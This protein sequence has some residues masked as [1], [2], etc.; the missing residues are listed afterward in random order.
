MIDYESALLGACPCD[1]SPL[2][3]L[4]GPRGRRGGGRRRLG[5]RRYV[6]SGGYAGGETVIVAPILSPFAPMVEWREDDD[7]ELGAIRMSEAERGF[8]LARDAFRAAEREKNRARMDTRIR[9]VR[10]WWNRMTQTERNN[11][12]SDY[13]FLEQL[14]SN[15]PGASEAAAESRARV[16]A[17]R[18][19]L[20][21]ARAAGGTSLFSHLPG[22][23]RDEARG[24]AEGVRK[25][26]AHPLAKVA[27]VAAV[28]LLGYA[29]YLRASGGGRRR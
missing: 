12:A 14:N 13:A 7:A 23:V 19:A 24:M 5:G 11:Y 8:T 3:A 25:V 20:E 16:D 9:E 10:Y 17:A 27:G 18:A 22:A 1:T 4:E 26:F 15:V 6:G 2:G 28:G 21:R 29:L